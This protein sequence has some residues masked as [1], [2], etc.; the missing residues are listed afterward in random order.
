MLKVRFSG[1]CA[2]RAGSHAVVARAGEHTTRWRKAVKSQKGH[3][4]GRI[5]EI[6]AVIQRMGENSGMQCVCSASA[7]ALTNTPA[8][9]KLNTPE[10]DV[11]LQQVGSLEEY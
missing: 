2:S 3:E 4:I 9:A 1:T 7:L 5:N 8:S 10:G 6:S 11:S